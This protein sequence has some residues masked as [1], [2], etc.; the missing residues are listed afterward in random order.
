VGGTIC[1]H[2]GNPLIQYSWGL[3]NVTNNIVE[4][5]ALWQGINLAKASGFWK[6]TIFRDY[7]IVIRSLINQ[8]SL[9]SKSLPRVISHIISIL[10]ILISISHSA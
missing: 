1:G 8:S 4:A 10:S 9:E 6:I 7:M 3:G 5:Y 2:G